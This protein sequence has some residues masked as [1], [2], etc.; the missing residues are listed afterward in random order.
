MGVPHTC[1]EAIA[2]CIFAVIPYNMIMI[3]FTGTFDDTLFLILH[4][5]L[6]LLYIYFAE[7]K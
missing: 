5:E 1:L 3:I 7:R 6:V 2:P 4:W